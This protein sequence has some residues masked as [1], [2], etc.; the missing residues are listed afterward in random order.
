LLKQELP[1][2][3]AAGQGRC[4][5]ALPLAQPDAAVPDDRSQTVWK[6]AAMISLDTPALRSSTAALKRFEP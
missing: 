3:E 4:V 2:Q 1:L 5:E 6:Q